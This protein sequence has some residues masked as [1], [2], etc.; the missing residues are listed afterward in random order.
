MYVTRYG[1]AFCLKKK[2]S[3]YKRLKYSALLVV[4]NDKPM[5][6]FC[7]YDWCPVI[8][9]RIA[10]V[11]YV[12]CREIT[13]TKM[14]CIVGNASRLKPMDAR[15]QAGLASTTTRSWKRYFRS[16]LPVGTALPLCVV[17]LHLPTVQR[18]LYLK[19]LFQQ[20][21]IVAVPQ[22]HEVRHP[23]KR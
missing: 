8:V 5:N 11:S 7:K 3:H 14:D 10:C 23:T 6:V 15:Q 13:T 19:L 17:A 16:T 20:C 9:F 12:F 18:R 2:R 21:T 1:K 4:G 22:N